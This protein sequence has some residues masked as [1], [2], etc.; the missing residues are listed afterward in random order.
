MKFESADVARY[1]DQNTASFLSHGQGGAH[2]IIHRAV[3]GEGVL[4]REQAFHF[5]HDLLQARIADGGAQRILDLGCGVG[6]SL[7]YIL[8]GKALSGF[9]VTNS[10]VQAQLARERLG[11]RASIAE[12]DFCSAPLPAPIDLAFG[13][14]SF[15]QAPDAAA[16]FENVA[17][18]LAAGGYLV[19]CDD[20]LADDAPNDDAPNADA[21]NA[22]A[23]N[24]DAP[25]ADAPN[26]DA[27]NADAPNA[28][29]PNADA[30]NADAPNADAPNDDAPDADDDRWVRELRRGWQAS[31]LLHREAVDALAASHG[32]ELVEDRDL[33]AFLELDRPRDRVLGLLIALTRPF[34]SMS[35]R[36]ESHLGG[37][38]LRQCL[39]RG[40]VAY[41]YRA[42]KAT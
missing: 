1:Y 2:G 6:A 18:S 25:N 32:L 38:A 39:K 37:N 20:F 31:S 12:L 42:W 24:A 23:P 33:T 9:G 3:W 19:L 28:D 22:D 16:F 35:A 15:A 40:L 41:R 5:V 7:E 27:P 34:V 30:P 14:E 11:D 4:R 10:A 29:A 36:L 21:P 13:I 26:A 17:K 8:R